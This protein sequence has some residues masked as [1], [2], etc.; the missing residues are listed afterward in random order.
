MEGLS[1]LTRP[2]H[3]AFYSDSHYLIQGMKNWVHTWAARGWKR[4]RGS[5]VN[6]ELW[7]ELSRIAAGHS[8]EWRWVRGH[9]GQPKNEYVNRLAVEAATRQ[10]S[11]E[12]LVD[13]GFNAW[14]EA[15][16]N[17]DRFLE[18][19]DLPPA[20]PFEPDPPA[21]EPPSDAIL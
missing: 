10:K 15:Q 7:Q 13:S 17:E 19:L 16:Q 18:F 1:T 21:P 6:L 2:S 14:L 20:Q 12:G 9:A 11:S 3:V 5:I 8:V 4:K